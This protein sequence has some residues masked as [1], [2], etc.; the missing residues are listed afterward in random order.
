MPCIAARRVGDADCGARHL[1]RM[2]DSASY[3]AGLSE[4]S[5]AYRL[6]DIAH[7]IVA[8]PGSGRQTDANLE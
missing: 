6:G 2:I 1:L 4:D 3:A 5:L 8:D 7:V